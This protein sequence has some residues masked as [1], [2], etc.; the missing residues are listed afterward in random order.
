MIVDEIRS[1]NPPGRFLKQDPTTKLWYDI[2]EKKAL[3]K[4][5]Q[6]LREGAPEIMKE[7]GS[8]DN[9]EDDEE[10]VFQNSSADELPV[11]NRRVSLA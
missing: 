6:A 8:D 7:I 1:R 10:Q 9:G 3:D 2:G 5:R 11:S 4:T